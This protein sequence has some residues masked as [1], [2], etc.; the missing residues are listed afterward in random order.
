MSSALHTTIA[1]HLRQQIRAGELGVGDPIPSES[2]LRERW[3]SSRGPVRQ[4]LASLRAE[5]VIAGGPG[6][7]PVVRTASLSQPFDTLLSYSA[8]A[9]AIG[10]TPGQ[11]TLELALRPADEVA[12]E[13][14]RLQVGTP[15]V[16][17]LR[18]R[19][20]DGEEAMLERAIFVEHVGRLL[21]AFDCDS[22]SLW[23][24]LQSRGVRFATASHVIDAVAADAS[25]AQHL[26]IV[27]GSPLLR[28][29][30]TTFGPDGDVIEYHDDRY[31]PGRVSFTLENAL[32]VRTALTRNAQP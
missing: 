15:V 13:R 4:A 14:L 16:H 5:G 8:W 2:Q 29:Q 7:P 27:E 28:Q 21:F 9:R 32:D 3:G 20:L 18:L 10:R 6:K 12:A 31:L 22:G 11:R 26:R 25:D 1:D 23:A 30:R 17:V 19:L 24:H